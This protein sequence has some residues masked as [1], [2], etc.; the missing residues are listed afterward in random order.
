MLIRPDWQS[1][2]VARWEAQSRV[3]AAPKGT[4]PAQGGQK[5]EMACQSL[6]LQCDA[7]T[8]CTLGRLIG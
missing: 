2:L 8:P 6:C 7:R 4:T 5:R 3:P 1:R